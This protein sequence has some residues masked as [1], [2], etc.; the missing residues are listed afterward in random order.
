VT[1]LLRRTDRHLAW[2]LNE[3]CFGGARPG[4]YPEVTLA[5]LVGGSTSSRVLELPAESYNVTEA[6]LL[7]LSAITS[8]A[9][10]RT[11]FE[12]G[13][14]DGRTT[15]NLA[16][17]VGTAG[18]VYTLN[19]P[20]DEDRTHYQ[21]I[22]VGSRF[23]G[24]PEAERISQLWGDS[25]TFDFEPYCGRCD[26][27]FIDADHSDAAVWADSQTAL[28]LADRRRGIVVWHDALRYGVQTA[29]PRLMRQDGLPIHLIAGTNLALLCFLQG[30]AVLPQEWVKAIGAA[31]LPA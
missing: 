12:F 16:A 20:L 24:S 8:Y 18:H 30:T 4:V 28:R 9:R 23:A 11:V 3:V 2:K 31:R 17:N 14:A 15:R 19:I 13:T 22:P 21:R 26:L 1:T 27:I 10:A 25:R 29:L 5:N 7:S 6:E